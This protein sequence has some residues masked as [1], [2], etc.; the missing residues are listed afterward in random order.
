MK[1]DSKLEVLNFGVKGFG[2]DQAFLRYKKDGIKYNSHIVL[3]GFMSENIFRN[4]NVFRPFYLKNTKF[5]LTKPRF[6]L[7]KNKLVLLNN[8]TQNLSDYNKILDDPVNMISTLGTNDFYYQRKYKKGPFD[9]LPSVRLIKTA[10][11]E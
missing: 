2:T 6:I 4:V 9:S 5:P 3:I 8:P 11:Y 10:L 1:I 7:E